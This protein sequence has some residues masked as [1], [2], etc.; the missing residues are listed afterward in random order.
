V[1][2]SGGRLER[3][4]EVGGYRV[5]ELIGQGGMGMVYRAT[6][7][8]LNR[9]YALKVLTPEIAEDE[10]FRQRFKREMRIAASLHHPNVVGIHYAGEQDGLLFLAMDYVHGTDL[11]QLLL[12]DGALEPNRA[13]ELLTQLASALDAAHRKGLVHRD[14]KPANALITVRDGEE[15]AYLTDFGLAK[16][17]DTVSGMTEKGSMVGTVDYMAPE[18]V[19]G[20]HTDA[21]T[22]VYALGCVFFQMLTGSVPYERENSVATLFAHVHDPPPALRAPLADL[23]PEFGAVIEKAMAK[24]PD[25][26]YLSAGDFARDAAAALKGTRYAGS[27]TIVA[28]GEAKPTG[29]DQGAQAGPP[30]ADTPAGP[31]TLRTAP[32]SESP[33]LDSSTKIRGT[34]GDAGPPTVASGEPAGA[35]A[36]RRPFQYRWAALALLIGAAVVAVVI[37][38]TSGGSSG[39]TGLKFE[40]AARPVPL[41]RVN[42]SGTAT[43]SL[44][45]NRATVIVDANGLLNGSPH[46]MHIHAFG[47][48]ICPT[49][50]A[51]RRY[52]GHLAIST[53]DGLRFYGPP[54]VSLTESGDATAGSHLAFNRSPATG[55]IRYQ[56]TITIPAQVTQAIRN[57]NAVIVIHGIDYNGNGVYDNVLNKSELDNSVPQEATAPALCGPLFSTQ[58]AARPRSGTVYTAMLHVYHPPPNQQYLLLCHLA[59]VAVPAGESSAAARAATGGLA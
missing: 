53:T 56:R 20:D 6:N 8:A 32:G 17:H 26:R 34:R 4:S 40:A 9:I 30:L 5:D 13:V 52:N 46:L 27:P 58:V 7:V 2:V 41:N 47:Q 48:G 36:G 44:Q 25:D 15:H 57:G 39:A 10:Q 31:E 35:G 42:G 21:R 55:T 24:Q 49:A 29:A 43:I 18:Q 45:G 22:D 28:T 51:A 50:A 59:G 1:H 38:L 11:R 16:R 33:P 19:T 37:A 3:G 12:K 54:V 23:Y 14:V